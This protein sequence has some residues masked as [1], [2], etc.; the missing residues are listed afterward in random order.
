M[1]DPPPLADALSTQRALMKKAVRSSHS[2]KGALQI[3]PDLALPVH[4]WRKVVTA[5][6][7]TMKTVS[8]AALVNTALGGSK[9][10]VQRRAAP[11][12]LVC[13]PAV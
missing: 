2:Y 10:L 13:S 1:C 11:R 5:S 8:K 6:A 7:P 4:S 12:R 3:G 9:P